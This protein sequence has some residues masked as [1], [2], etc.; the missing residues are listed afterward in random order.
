MKPKEAYNFVKITQNHELQK[1]KYIKSNLRSLAEGQN[2]LVFTH[3]IFNDIEPKKSSQKVK[4]LISC[5][6]HIYQD[7]DKCLSSQESEF[8]I[9][10]FDLNT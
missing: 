9:P 2:E 5:L 6:E 10:E 3:K 4:Y 7:L 8:V 1:L